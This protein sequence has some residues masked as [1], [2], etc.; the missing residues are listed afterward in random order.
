MFSSE[1]L[2][3]VRV[4]KENHFKT[5]SMFLFLIEDRSFQKQ[6]LIQVWGPDLEEAGILTPGEGGSCALRGGAPRAAGLLPGGPLARA[7]GPRSALP[8]ETT[9]RDRDRA[10]GLGEGDPGS[11]VPHLVPWTGPSV[12]L[13]S[14]CSHAAARGPSGKGDVGGRRLSPA[15]GSPLCV[16]SE[17]LAPSDFKR[18]SLVMTRP[19]VVPF[20]SPGRPAGLAPSPLL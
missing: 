20:F 19:D 3:S 9:C 16:D 12:P 17:V 15:R 2:E 4:Q 5:M 7:R 10:P 11:P 18:G 1:G 6:L 14:S 13:G 8:C